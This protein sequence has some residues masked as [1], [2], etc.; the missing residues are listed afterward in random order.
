MT[1]PKGIGEG[2]AMVPDTVELCMRQKDR[3]P[4]LGV[5]H[6][7]APDGRSY[8]TRCGSTEPGVIYRR[9]PVDAAPRA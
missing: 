8:C 1:G 4:C 5:I 3:F 7:L 2:R 9:E 6:R